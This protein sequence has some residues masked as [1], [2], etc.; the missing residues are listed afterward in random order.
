[1]NRLET[2]T[3]ADTTTEEFLYDPVGNLE[4][5]TDNAGQTRLFAYDEL[6]RLETVSYPDTTTVVMAYDEMS[7]LISVTERNGDVTEI[8]YDDLD[9]VITVTRTKDTGNDTPEGELH[10]TYDANG[11]RLSI[12][13]GAGELWSVSEVED[14]YGTARY[15]QARYG[16]NFDAMNRPLGI[17]KA[18]T[19]HTAFTYD[20]EGRRTGVDYANGVD[21][22]VSFDIVGRPLELATRVGP[23]TLLSATYSYD[24]ASN[25]TKQVSGNDTI[26]Y[27]IDDDGKLIGESVNRFVQDGTRN[28]TTGGLE[29]MSLTDQGL[30]L[31]ALDDSFS[32]D[33]IDCDRWRIGYTN[34]DTRHPPPGFFSGRRNPTKRRP[35]PGQSSWLHQQDLCQG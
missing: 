32:G 25:R 26:D 9:R 6:N 11:N 13:D 5:Y 16:G 7:N 30:E 18:G 29:K 34:N 17:A 33:E 14:L 19:V 31:L 24:I 4:S 20:H 28:F 35:A 12:S 1:M 21:T 2:I 15:G 3:Y 27:Q 23:A 10:F 8:D 22:K